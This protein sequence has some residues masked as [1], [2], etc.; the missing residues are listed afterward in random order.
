[1]KQ[2]CTVDDQAYTVRSVQST[3]QGNLYAIGFGAL[4]ILDGV[5]IAGVT[6]TPPEGYATTSTGDFP[7]IIV[8]GMAGMAAIAG[9]AF[10]ICK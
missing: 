10:F 3:D 1:M 5:E 7:M 8:Y 4:D 9:I 6:P 2:K